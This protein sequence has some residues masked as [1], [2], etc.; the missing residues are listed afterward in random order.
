MPSTSNINV[1]VFSYFYFLF[2]TLIL[3]L[4]GPWDTRS[5][6]FLT[7]LAFENLWY[8]R[9]NGS[10]IGLYESHNDHLNF[11]GYNKAFYIYRKQI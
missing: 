8:N 7:N 11:P 9:C 2:L 1:Y 6:V 5:Y 4:S 3:V 10:D